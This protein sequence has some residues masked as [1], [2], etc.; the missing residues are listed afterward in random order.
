MPI[1]LRSILPDDITTVI[2][3]LF[4]YFR[5][6]CSKVLHVDALNRFEQ[7]VKITLCKMEMIFP[8]GFFTVMVHLVVHL[9]AE[10]WISGP[11]NYRWM[12]F[13]ERF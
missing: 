5:G 10:C 9:A 13:I 6:I 7:S 12:Y 1:A 3:E 8:P 11:V 2:F 4:A